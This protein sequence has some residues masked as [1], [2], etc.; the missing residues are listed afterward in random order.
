MKNSLSHHMKRLLITGLLTAAPMTAAADEE[1][2]IEIFSPEGSG[3]QAQRA[4]LDEQR[5]ELGVQAGLLSV[6]DFST[7]MSTG[8]SL[9]YH[10][11]PGFSLRGDYSRAT[12]GRATFEEVADGNFLRPSERRFEQVSLLAGYQVLSGRAYMGSQRRLGSYLYV[13]AGPNR[14]TFAGQEAT[15]VTL[16][17][18]HKTLVT[19][20]L[21]INI[22]V[23]DIIARREFLGSEGTTHNLDANIGVSFLF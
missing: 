4:S 13:Q 18:T 12:L 15:G 19:R 23:R 1:R 20:W 17:L 11:G 14:V 5:F 10:F 22:E 3:S 8:V 16:G 7:D 6:D 2:R 21:S 9:T